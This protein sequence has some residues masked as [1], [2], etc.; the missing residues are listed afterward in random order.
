MRRLGL[1]LIGVTLVASGCAAR[2]VAGGRAGPAG[3]RAAAPAARRSATPA[4]AGSPSAK[5]PAIRQTPGAL[6]LAA[7]TA[8]SA[9]L[10]QTAASPPPE[11][12]LFAARMAALWLAV[13]EGDPALAA[14]SFF[15]LGAYQ[16]LKAIG[17]PTADWQNRL[18]ADFALDISAAHRLLGPGAQFL[19]TR[20]PASEGAWIPPGACYNRLG[21]W[22]DPGARLVYRV[23]GQVRSF[24]IASLISWR[25]EWFV[26]HLGAVL[27]AS[28][29]G[30]VDAPSVGVGQPGPPGGC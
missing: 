21:Y 26:V 19:Q 29:T 8:A 23:A 16:Q 6:G 9:A 3:G 28:A 10:P 7:V 2:P 12:P 4:L 25:G 13:L 27:R 14:S 5:P 1:V 30:I 20:V 15:P 18:W 11:S 24:G 17:N 22:H